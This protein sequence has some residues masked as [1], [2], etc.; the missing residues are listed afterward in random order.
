MS[1]DF[2]SFAGVSRWP[3]HDAGMP[4]ARATLD[5]ASDGRIATTDTF[6][7]Y[8]GSDIGM[9]AESLG[10]GDLDDDGDL[11]AIVASPGVPSARG[12]V[13]RNDLV[14]L[15]Q[16]TPFA[17]VT[18]GAWT[19]T[20]DACTSAPHAILYAP[21]LVLVVPATGFDGCA[22][23]QTGPFSLA[24][25]GAVELA[26][27]RGSDVI[28]VADLD[29]DDQLDLLF[30]GAGL[31]SHAFVSMRDHWEEH[32]AFPVDL[33]DLAAATFVD[34]DADG[35]LDLVTLA[36]TR[37]SGGHVLRG[38]GGGAFASTESTV[39]LETRGVGA[40]RLAVADLDGDARTDLA[41]FDVD[42]SP[43]TVSFF[44]NRS[45][46]GALAFDDTSMTLTTPLGVGDAVFVTS[47][48][49]DDDGATDLVV[50]TGGD[51]FVVLQ[52]RGDATFSERRFSGADVNDAHSTSLGDV[53]LDGDLDIVVCWG[54]TASPITRECSLLANQTNGVDFVEL[55]LRGRATNPHA[56]GAR[57]VV[58]PAGRL[59]D[60]AA[61]PLME[62][63]VTATSASH[64]TTMVHVGLPPDGLFDVR[65]LWPDGATTDILGVERG[66]HLRVV[67]P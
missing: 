46:D 45:T 22:Y 61:R 4:V 14:A 50:T 15:G 3:D 43:A 37:T 27:P 11:D 35:T 28:A 2:P 58:F 60:F 38:L 66:A 64:D 21:P 34:L 30:G 41:L 44:W 53:D 5:F 67:E 8:W 56:I 31:P 13:L 54:P 62:R 48:D 40:R 25:L 32:T 26:M 63:A 20:S 10:L 1:F 36:A 57:V 55:A 33:S 47:G 49:A 51:T 12:V 42:A 65:V 24:A 9:R 23:R 19:T 29:G 52:N 6:M 59:G 39:M 18:A 7:P 17:D 16:V